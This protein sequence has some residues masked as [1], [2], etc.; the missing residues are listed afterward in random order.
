MKT[1]LVKAKEVVVRTYAIRAVSEKDALNKINICFNRNG[2]VV[3]EMV[4]G[5]KI[6]D[7]MEN[8]G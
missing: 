6:E 3:N 4:C 7:V 5:C 1:Y 8:K 2:N